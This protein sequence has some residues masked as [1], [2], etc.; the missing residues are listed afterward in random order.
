MHIPPEDERTP[1]SKRSRLRRREFL[2]LTA[3]SL[4]AAACRPVRDGVPTIYPRGSTVIP[5]PTPTLPPRGINTAQPRPQAPPITAIRNLYEKSF[6]GTPDLD[7]AD[8][9]QVQIDG[10]VAN[11]LTLNLTDLRAAPA[12]RVI[13]TLQCISN[14]VGGGLI[15]NVSWDTTDAAPFFA[16]ANVLPSAKY[17]LFEAADGYT[18]SV[19]VEE[20]LQDGVLFVYGAEGAPLPPEHGYPLRI[21]IPGLYGQKQ[22]KWL[23]RIT[24]SSEDRLGY[25]EGD[26]RGWSNVAVVKTNSA[27]RTPDGREAFAAP[28]AVSGV[29]FAGKRRITQV[30][31]A[32][33][34]AS[35]R[36][37]PRIWNPTRLVQTSDPLVWTWW[38]W[39]W[40]PTGVGVFRLAVRATDETGYAQAI[41]P[42]SLI[43]AAFPDG[44]DAIHAALVRVQ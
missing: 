15:G 38:A 20:L 1:L 43:G 42:N 18:T 22:P 44:T 17:A 8:N 16:R 9:W 40:T 5:S 19:K 35:E 27:L 39:E 28:I 37:L 12:Q 30:E 26:G 31:I 4:L 41:L 25:W 10:L 11:P 24:F 6:R 36:R 2:G 3:L 33:D 34:D 21:L 32:V 13:R 23:T 7:N 29:A 14:P